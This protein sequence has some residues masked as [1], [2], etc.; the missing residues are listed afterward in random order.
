MEHKTNIPLFTVALVTYRQRHLLNDCLQSVF[1]QDYGNIE[2]IICD[3]HSCDFDREE[4]LAYI[5]EHKGPNITAVQVYQHEQ[6]VGTVQNCQKAFELSHGVYLKLQAGDDMLAEEDTLTDMAELFQKKNCKLIFSRARGCTYEGEKTDDLYPSEAAFKQAEKCDAEGLFE[7]IGTACWGKYVNAPAVFWKR[8]FLEQMGGFDTSYQYTEDW[9][10][11]LRVCETGECPCY[12]DKVTVLYRYGGISNSQP[13]Q[14]LLMAK[15]HYR[16]SARMLR[17][18]AVPNF[19]RTGNKQAYLR[20]IVAAKEIEGRATSEV[21][22]K[23]FGLRQKMAWKLRNIS[24]YW[25][26]FVLKSQMG[27]I[28]YPLK[29]LVL[30]DLCILLL[31]HFKSFGLFPWDMSEV[32]A[33]VLL[34]SWAI[35]LLQACKRIAAEGIHCL[36]L[37]RKG[38]L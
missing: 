9:P 21:D 13:E 34:C 26:I 14:N 25:Q 16:E 7:L 3:D 19:Q 36:A 8:E 4:V 31:F 22:W 23:T 12:V 28:Y 5:Q 11:W 2:L 38:V 37:F 30:W 18:I 29:K 17:E 20:A 1:R 24:F 10:M 27:N 33:V 15:A 6:N 32:W 35:T